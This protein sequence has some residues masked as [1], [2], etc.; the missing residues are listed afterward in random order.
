MANNA[1]DLTGEVDVISQAKNIKKLLKM[2]FSSKSQISMMVHKVDNS[3]LID[4]FDIHK[5]LL[6]K[7]KDDWKWLREFYLESVKKDMQ[8]KCVPK[9]K[10]T[11]DYLQNKNMLSKFLYR[12]V[13]EALN[14]G[15]SLPVSTLNR[16]VSEQDDFSE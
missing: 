7:Q 14:S 16:D 6:R 1:L 5:N 11:R 15:E 9:K 10:K 8:V 4:D 12:S 3:L 13:Q 2:P